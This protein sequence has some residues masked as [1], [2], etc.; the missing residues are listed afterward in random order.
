ML[1]MLC[2]SF[3]DS[4]TRGVTFSIEKSYIKVIHNFIILLVLKFD[5]HK[6]NRLEIMIITRSI[7]EFVQIL[8]K[9]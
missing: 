5:S 9:F 7:T 2:S 1:M 4:N 8:N 3:S 6:S